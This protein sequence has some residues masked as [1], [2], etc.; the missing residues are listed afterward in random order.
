M[1]GCLAEDDENELP[2]GE[3]GGAVGLDAAV[4]ALGDGGDLREGLGLIIAL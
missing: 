3:A 4:A 1:V 2:D